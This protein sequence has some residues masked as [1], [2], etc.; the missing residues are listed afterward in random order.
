[1]GVADHM[2]LLRLLREF[3]AHLRIAP[4]CARNIQ[5]LTCLRMKQHP[6]IIHES[7]PLTKALFAL[8]Q[9]RITKIRARFV[10]RNC[11]RSRQPDSLQV[12]RRT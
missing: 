5:L 12:D 1:M 10:K 2:M 11:S 6:S 7:A 8:P 9:N 3:T 4:S